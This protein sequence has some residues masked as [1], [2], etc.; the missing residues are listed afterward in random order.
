MPQL[1][2]VDSAGSTS[3]LAFSGSADPTVKR[4][5]L[6]GWVVLGL[7]LSLMPL[8]ITGL[9]EYQPGGTSLLEILSNEE[10]L[11]VA[12]TLSGAAAADTLVN[13]ERNIWKFLLG[14]VTMLMTLITMAGFILFKGNLTHLSH[15]VIVDTTQLLFLFTALLSLI[16]EANSGA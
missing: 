2:N 6:I 12:F 1:Q 4:R 8:G 7:L 10:L 11:T 5:R 15:D 9:M 16:C 14:V 13:T 3:E